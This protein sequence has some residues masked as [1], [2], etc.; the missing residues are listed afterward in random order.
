MITRRRFLSALAAT[1]GTTGML[2]MKSSAADPIPDPTIPRRRRL[3]RSSKT[4]RTLSTRQRPFVM[5]FPRMGMFL[6]LSMTLME[7]RSPALSMK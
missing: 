2:G 3:M 6:C 5:R 4:T 1:A 7:G